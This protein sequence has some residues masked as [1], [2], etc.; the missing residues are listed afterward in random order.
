M[1]RFLDAACARA[2]RRIEIASEAVEALSGYSWPGNVRE[3][4][5][6]VERLVL[7]SQCQRDRSRVI[8]RCPSDRW[9]RA[10]GRAVHA[11]FR[12][13]TSSNDGI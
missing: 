10:R 12:R 6:T 2:G 11:I 8:F 4:E 7:F 3:L 13:S 9:A 5:N 1:T